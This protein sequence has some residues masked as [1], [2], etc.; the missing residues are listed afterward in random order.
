MSALTPLEVWFDSLDADAIQAIVDERRIESP[1]LDFK[2]VHTT[3]PFVGDPEQETVAKILNAL[4][5]SSGG[6]VIFG[7]GTSKCEHKVDRADSLVLLENVHRA[8]ARLN[9]ILPSLSNPPLTGVRAK[10]IPLNG[11]GGVVAVLVPESRRPPHMTLKGARQYHHRVGDNSVAMEHHSV[12]DAFARRAVPELELETRVLIGN[13]VSGPGGA[14][15]HPELLIGIRNTGDVIA[16]FPFLQISADKSVCQASEFGVDGNRNVGLPR[17]PQHYAPG[18]VVFAGGQNDVIHPGTTLQVTKFRCA[19]APIP[20]E[21]Y[22]DIELRYCLGAEG[23]ET[24]RLVLTIPGSELV[25]KLQ[26]QLRKPGGW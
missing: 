12:V 26:E 25:A 23:A 14:Y 16:K 22:G 20:P 21:R 1:T 9:Q 4:A 17:R 15:L 6:V 19:P 2:R 11:T 10:P 5:N 13:T 24:R 7:I 3:N 18:E 8:A